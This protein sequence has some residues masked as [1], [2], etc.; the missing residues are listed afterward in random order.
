MRHSSSNQPSRNPHHF[1]I[2]FPVLCCRV[3]QKNSVHEVLDF[4]LNFGVNII[5]DSSKNGNDTVARYRFE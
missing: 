5:Q 1:L 4:F 3:S 2:F